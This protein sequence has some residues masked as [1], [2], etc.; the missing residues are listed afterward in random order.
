MS[1]SVG[2]RQGA[3]AIVCVS[4]RSLV[5]GLRSFP[6]AVG[7]SRRDRPAPPLRPWDREG[8]RPRHAPRRSA[9]PSLSL[10]PHRF[11]GIGRYPIDGQLSPEGQRERD[12]E[13]TYYR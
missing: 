1:D 5:R 3:G 4:R 6:G 8:P 2:V 13:I 7:R 11:P 10:R 12:R 9:F